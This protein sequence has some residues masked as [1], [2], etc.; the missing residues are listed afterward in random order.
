MVRDA[1]PAW[2]VLH[3]ARSAHRVDAYPAVLWYTHS[4]VP[5]CVQTHRCMAPA[6]TAHRHAWCTLLVHQPVLVFPLQSLTGT[7]AGRCPANAGGTCVPAA[8]AEQCHH[9]PCRVGTRLQSPAGT[10]CL[11]PQ[12]W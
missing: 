7:T 10:P 1:V 6:R 8:T 9:A 2:Q 3:R 11:H 5:G 4:N 12:G